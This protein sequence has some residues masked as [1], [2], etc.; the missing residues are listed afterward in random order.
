M[1]KHK[2]LPYILQLLPG[3]GFMFILSPF[4][5]HWFIHGSH[6]RYIWIIN[7]P[8]PFYSFGSGPFLMFIYAALFLFGST[9]LFI[10]NAVKNR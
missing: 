9:L 7:G 10:A 5:L 6:D 3:L 4:I 8:Y 2:F 1:I